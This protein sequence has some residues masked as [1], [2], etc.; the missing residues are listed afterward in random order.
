MANNRIVFTMCALLACA[1]VACKGDSLDA[2]EEI[3]APSSG[4][5]IAVKFIGFEG[6]GEGRG[7][8]IKLY[9]HGDKKAFNY[10]FLLRYYDGDEALKIDTGPQAGRDLEFTSLGGHRHVCGAKANADIELSG[11]MLDVPKAATRAE[12]VV[13][14]VQAIDG[15]TV[16]DW[17]SQDDWMEWPN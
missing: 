10:T 17:W 8:K 9:N 6:E 15:E 11:R 2:V 12:V 16:E 1:A 5:P 3:A 14:K 7:V 13:S 4:S